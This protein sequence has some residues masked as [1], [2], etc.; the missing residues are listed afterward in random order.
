M[1]CNVRRRFRR[2]GVAGA[3][4]RT[5]RRSATLLLLLTVLG[6]GA[7]SACGDEDFTCDEVEGQFQ[8]QYELLSGDCTN[9]FEPALVDIPEGADSLRMH[10]ERGAG[11]T[12]VQTVVNVSGC[13]LSV[14]QI[15]F[16][17]QRRTW[18]MIGEYDVIDSGELQGTTYRIEY[19]AADTEV[20]RANF[21]AIL[22]QGEWAA[23]GTGPAGQ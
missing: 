5:A 3:G 14:E 23:G 10:N 19:D 1:G 17:G 11:G 9:F 16:Q 12:S 4:Q 22:R 20:C 8:P 21:G 2:A 7:T 13:S 18:R 6:S 15:A